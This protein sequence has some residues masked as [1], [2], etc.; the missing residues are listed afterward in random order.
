MK[1][2]R[3][4]DKEDYEEAIMMVGLDHEETQREIEYEKKLDQA[5]SKKAKGKGKNSS[6]PES[7]NHKGDRTEPYKKG[8]KKTQYSNTSKSKDKDKPKRM[9]HIKEEALKDIPA[10]LQE[11]RR[12]KKLCL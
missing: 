5:Q 11:K 2:G 4:Y 6:K 12:V 10:L 7:L 3:T 1:L 9:H 8:Q